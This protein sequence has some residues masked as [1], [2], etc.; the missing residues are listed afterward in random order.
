MTSHL[1]AP[2]PS[3]RR[4][5]LPER[6]AFHF[7]RPPALPEDAFGSQVCRRILGIY[8]LGYYLMYT[9]WVQLAW[10]MGALV[11]TG[12][13]IDWKHL[14]RSMGR[15][16]L[17][18]SGAVFLGW[19]TLRSFFASGEN[20]GS[21]FMTALPWLGGLVW[22]LLFVAAVWQTGIHPRALA[23]W[24]V[25]IGC[26][27]AF[28][29]LVSFVLF[30]LVLPSHAFGER[31]QNWF[32]FGGL[33]PV[34][35]GLGF[36][37][38]ALWVICI[39]PEWRGKRT[40]VLLPILQ[41]ILILALLFTRSRGGLLAL[42]AGLAV[43]L[44]V[45]GWRKMWRDWLLLALVIGAFE[46]ADPFVTRYAEYQAKVR[47]GQTSN[48]ATSLQEMLG[49]A[50][51]GRLNIYRA[52]VDTLKDPKAWLFGIGQWGTDEQW[53]S[54]IDPQ[55]R[56]DHLHSAYLATLVQGGLVGLGLL[57]FTLGQGL[58]RARVLALE[59]DDL[60]LALLSYG[61]AALLFDG[62]TFT[63]MNSLPLFEPLLL[64]FPLVMAASA[65]AQKKR[66]IM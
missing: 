37:F 41:V 21:A 34:C 19:M 48:G 65:W 25:V 46:A 64:T 61:C 2:E 39:K 38:A 1:P 54:R 63:R 22:L 27:A 66:A 53:R 29:A 59:G 43:L 42:G 17:L 26:A 56:S 57:A 40:G 50:D 16:P 4:P 60:W 36:G 58:W 55:W 20:E 5:D 7:L 3:S 15:D 52:G 32:V 24:G 33:N 44:L 18:G 14:G 9:H 10:L 23:P 35:A 62:Q 12:R 45:R 49:R 47:T 11:M 51:S 31:L 30:Y 8:L 13:D 6:G 28:A